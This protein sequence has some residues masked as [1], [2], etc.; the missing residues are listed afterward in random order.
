MK[1]VSSIRI[2]AVFLLAASAIFAQQSGPEATEWNTMRSDNGEFSIDMPANYSYFYDPAGMEITETYGTFVF[3]EMRL[4]NA[5]ANKTFM[6]LEIYKVPDPKKYAGKLIDHN[7]TKGAKSKQ[8][9]PGFFV[10]QFD[11]K[12][13]H[14]YN[15][16]KNVAINY[17][18]RYIASK[19]HLYVVTVANRGEEITAAA[20]RFIDSIH[21]RTEDPSTGSDKNAINISKLKPV[22]IDQMIADET[23]GSLLSGVAIEKVPAPKTP[24]NPNGILILDKPAPTYSEQ[25]RKGA[26]RGTLRLRVTFD[27][28][29]GVTKVGF[30]S[31]LDHS[32]TRNAFFCALRI[33]FIPEEKDGQ[34][35]TVKK[36]LEYSFNIY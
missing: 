17:Q 13:I 34:E 23:D 11:L 14:S 32:L 28:R 33:K 24:P 20:R 1:L 21:L 29:G 10:Q 9:I 30:I 6:S 15:L 35:V 18:T 12:K 2:V 22:T 5:S 36:T 25:A 8:T 16:E 3:S 26:I 4:L 7:D 31:T 27:K 19:D